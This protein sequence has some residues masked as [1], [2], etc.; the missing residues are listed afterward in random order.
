MT[1]YVNCVQCGDD[2]ETRATGRAVI[3][4]CKTCN[5]NRQAMRHAEIRK[6]LRDAT[7]AAYTSTTRN[8]SRV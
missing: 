6:R 5:G 3:P 7:N 8:W 2:F 1:G 4:L